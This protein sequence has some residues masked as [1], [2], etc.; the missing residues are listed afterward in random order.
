MTDSN[1]T[2]E[3]NNEPVPG[4][5]STV[6]PGLY[7]ETVQPDTPDGVTNVPN[8]TEDPNNFTTAGGDA[9]YPVP[10]L[11]LGDT[12]HPPTITEA[13]PRIDEVLS[14]LHD[15]S[16]Q[17]EQVTTDVNQKIDH[18]LQHI[19]EEEDNQPPVQ[20]EGHVVLH[21]V[22]QPPAPDFNDGNQQY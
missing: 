8:F 6:T 20:Y 14:L 11:D 2:P 9:S 1:F 17:I 4:T 22:S 21:P 18:L 15:L 12:Y 3:Y 16:A 19:H 10:D 5:E 7:P 13:D